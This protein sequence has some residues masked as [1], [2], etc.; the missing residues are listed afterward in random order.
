[1]L[2]QAAGL[3][4]LLSSCVLLSHWKLSLDKAGEHYWYY[5]YNYYFYSCT[6]SLAYF[7]VSSS[8]SSKRRVLLGVLIRLLVLWDPDERECLSFVLIELLSQVEYFFMILIFL[9]N[10]AIFDLIIVEQFE[11]H[12]DTD[13]GEEPPC[14]SKLFSKENNN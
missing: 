2:E 8:S 6:N 11:E 12:A 9:G 3:S 4:I 7:K 14:L 13:N 5:Y 10:L 1:M